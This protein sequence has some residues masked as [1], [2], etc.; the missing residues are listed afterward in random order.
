MRIRKDKTD[1]NPNDVE[2]IKL[3]TI[4]A[5]QQQLLFKFDNGQDMGVTLPEDANEAESLYL[6]QY[7]DLRAI[8]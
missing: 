2:G 3:Q 8:W 6:M 1:C 4:E 7:E 5:S